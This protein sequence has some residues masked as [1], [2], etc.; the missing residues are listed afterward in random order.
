MTQTARQARRAKTMRAWR[1]KRAAH[2]KRWTRRWRMYRYTS[3][4]CYSARR[5][6]LERKLPFSIT[7]ADIKIPE[8]CPVLGMKLKKCGYRGS[9]NSPTVDRIIPG[10]GYVPGNIVVISHR[11]N[12]IKNN[13]T[14]AELRAIVRWLRR[15]C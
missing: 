7:P 14:L 3:I 1:I 8:M 13:A 4:M 9:D 10:K 6:A 11:A 15:K 2:Y 12:R 5:R